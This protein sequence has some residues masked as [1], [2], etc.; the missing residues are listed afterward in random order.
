MTNRDV[1]VTTARGE[2][3]VGEGAGT[4]TI[5]VAE[6]STSWSGVI[7]V[8]VLPPDLVEIVVLP[9]GPQTIRVG[10]TLP[11]EASGMFSDSTLVPP[12]GPT[13]RARRAPT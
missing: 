7:D 6:A 12:D 4:T 5:E 13:W 9:P 8:T 3:V 11:F 1:A 10:Q 2:M